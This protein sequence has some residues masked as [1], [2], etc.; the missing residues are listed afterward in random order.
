MPKPRKP[1]RLRPLKTLRIFC[2]GEKTEPNYLKGY[3]RAQRSDRRKTVVELEK[4]PKTTPVQLVEEAIRLKE[5]P[6]SLPNDEY[7][8]VYDRE[9]VAKYSDALHRK[10]FD[11][12]RAHGINLSIC[13]VCFEYW[14]LLHLVETSAPYASYADLKR[15]SALEAEIRKL[16]GRGYDKASSSIF[17]LVG[18]KAPDARVRALRLNQAGRSSAEVGRDRA[19]Q[20]NPYVGVVEL[21]TAIDDFR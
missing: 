14:I 3:L 11:L 12:G 13:N 9:S 19:Y 17:D 8:V 5:S 2:E 18:G 21:L 16:S 7:W 20:I 4:T 6:I 10:A 1:S 15:N